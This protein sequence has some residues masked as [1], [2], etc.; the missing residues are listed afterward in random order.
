MAGT[1]K[2]DYGACVDIVTKGSLKAMVAPGVLAVTVPIAVGVIFRALASP[3]QGSLGAE[4]VA[5][6]LMVGTITGILMATL[7]NNAGGAWDNAKKYIE[8]GV[9]GG[10]RSDAHKAAVVGDTVG[11]P[12]KD[13]AGPSLHVLI[14]LLS[15]ITLLMAP[16][17]I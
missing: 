12:F 14:K 15:T 2:P 11:D 8:T 16:L 17:F 10:K 1:S 3:E 6:F 5:G 7:L 4:A 13:T 9:H